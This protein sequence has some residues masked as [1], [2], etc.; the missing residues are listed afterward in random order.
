MSQPV[1]SYPLWEA[2]GFAGDF[3]ITPGAGLTLI[4]RD[5]YV[6]QSSIVPVEFSWTGNNGETLFGDSLTDAGDTWSIWGRHIVVVV[7]GQLGLHTEPGS[8]PVD[9]AVFGYQLTNP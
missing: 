5:I 1:Y 8:A 6:S 7:G 2:S 9:V 4:A 3:A